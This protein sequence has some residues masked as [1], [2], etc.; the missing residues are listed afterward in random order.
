[1]TTVVQTELL[2]SVVARFL[3]RQFATVPCKTLLQL[4]LVFPELLLSQL[5]FSIACLAVGL[6]FELCR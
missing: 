3:F 6:M 4:L 2:E 1:M 5:V